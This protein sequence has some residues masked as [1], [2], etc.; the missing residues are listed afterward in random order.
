MRLCY[1][2]MQQIQDEKVHTCP[3][4]GESLAIS[5][6]SPQY[7]PPGTVLQ[8]KFIV[9][10]P[11]GAGGFGNTYI[12]WSQILL[13]RVA[14]KEY[15]PEQITSRMPDGVTVSVT[16]GTMRQRFRN[17]LQ[18]FLEEARSVANLQDVRGVVEIYNFFE[19]NGTG[20]IV[21]EYLEGMDVRTILKKS[22]DKQD[23]EW[24]RKVILTVLYTLREIHKRGVLHRDIAPD[25]VFV[26][27]EGVVKLIDFGAAKHASELANLKQDIVL[28]VGYAPIEQYSRTAPQGPYTDLYAV[29]ALFYRM[30]TGMK[31]IPANER[32]VQDSLVV[33][34]EMGIK[35]PEQAELA[36]MVCLNIRPEFRLQSAGEFM[37]ALDGANFVPV[38]EREWILPPEAVSHSSRFGKLASLPTGIKVVAC[39]FVLCLI[40]GGAVGL[41]SLTRQEKAVQSSSDA[42][43]QL[44]VGNCVG[45]QWEDAVRLLQNQGFTVIAEPVYEYNPDVEEEQVTR[46]NIAAG[47]SADIGEEIVL[48]V[49]GGRSRFTM[50]DCIGMTSAEV[51]D[52]FEQ[53]GTV[54]EVREAYSDELEKGELISQSIAVGTVYSVL[55]SPALVFE[56]SLGARSDY[57]KKMPDLEGLSVK[58]AEKKLKDKGIVAKVKVRTD[59]FYSDVEKGK[60]VAQKPAKGKKINI[61][62]EKE[63][64]LYKSR[65]PKSTPVPT[66][67][68]TQTPVP[69]PSASVKPKKKTKSKPPEDRDFPSPEDSDL[70][71]IEEIW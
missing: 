61:R 27:N 54:A 25:N 62:E 31:P 44:F 12:G 59:R 47:E 70:P 11:L 37:E 63:I 45:K 46:Q 3:Y 9:G 65:G 53:R 49:S 67:K 17:G 43:G 48:T 42:A 18:Q 10:K 1:S 5:E 28:K 13:R 57:E 56:Y 58:Q 7:L 68:P 64:I 41:V 26:T 33:P 8:G 39:F 50:P 71:S 14:I 55:D 20:Y 22:G 69:R 19:A 66:S 29:A 2:C 60:V 36:I 21:M 16:E 52:Y 4:C 34:S 51:S 23:Y 24:C 30:L 40:G 6:P 32:V 35:L 38:Y 15:Y